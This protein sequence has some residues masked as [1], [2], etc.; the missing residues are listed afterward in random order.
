MIFGKAM[1]YEIR[2]T[3]TDNNGYI[4]KVGCAKFSFETKDSIKA[5]F[6][7]FIDDPK[8]MEGFY[9]EAGGGIEDRP[10]MQDRP[11]SQDRRPTRDENSIINTE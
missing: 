9:G 4:V 5:A 3:P 6:N 2:I 11:P 1:N 8:K 7:D 10:P